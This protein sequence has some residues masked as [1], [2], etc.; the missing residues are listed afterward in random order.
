MAKKPKLTR[1]QEEEKRAKMAKAHYNMNTSTKKIHIEN[2]KTVL[3][4]LGNKST[5]PLHVPNSTKYNSCYYLDKK[6][7]EI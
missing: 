3:P 5:V 6:I 1:I 2:N 4:F 7:L